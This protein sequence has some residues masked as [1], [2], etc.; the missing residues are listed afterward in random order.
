MLDKKKEVAAVYDS[1]SNIT[2]INEKLI[3]E[4]RKS[5]SK[6]KELLHTISGVQGKIA[7]KGNYLF[8]QRY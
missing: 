5:V 8:W 6:S 4:L 1:G 2:V 7:V 3:R